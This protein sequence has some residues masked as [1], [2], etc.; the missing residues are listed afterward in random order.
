M[1]KKIIKPSGGRHWARIHK[2]DDL[3][4]KVIQIFYGVSSGCRANGRV[5]LAQCGNAKAERG[6]PWKKQ[7][8]RTM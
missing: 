5:V 7:K 8:I 3:P 6:Q 4:M 1:F 2:I